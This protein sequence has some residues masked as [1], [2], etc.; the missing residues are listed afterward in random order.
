MLCLMRIRRGLRFFL[1][2]VLF[3][4][5]LPDRIPQ[6][7]QQVR[8]FKPKISGISQFHSSNSSKPPSSYGIAKR[9]YALGRS[10]RERPAARSVTRE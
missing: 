8:A 4:A 5:I 6:A 2:P 1:R 3:H 9:M 10:L 7:C